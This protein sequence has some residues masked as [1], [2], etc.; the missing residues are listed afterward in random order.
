[1]R[2]TAILLTFVFL[3]GLAAPASAAPLTAA[4][5]AANCNADG[6]VEIDGKQRYVR[7]TGVLELPCTVTLTPGSRLDF[8][9]VTIMGKSLSVISSSNDTRIRVLRSRLMMT[10]PLG[11]TT[12]C[13]SGN[14][15]VP[16]GNGRVVVRRS[17]LS[18]SS[19]QLMAS[20]DGANGRVVVKRSRLT[21]TGDQGIQIRA[22]DLG[23]VEGRVRV[24]RSVVTSAGDL[25]IRT[26][27]EGRT[28]VRRT[29]TL[30][31]G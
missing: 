14:D 13:C 20:S 29:R 27:T 23:G 18:G 26:G 17:S 19:I 31:E 9:R 15:E 12:G 28:S 30:V 22:S 4:D 24:R 21:A 1:M 8:R 2:R 7:G 25:L 16:E 5:F 6:E 10:G 11:L 3:I